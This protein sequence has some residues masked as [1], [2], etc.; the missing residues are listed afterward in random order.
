MAVYLMNVR[1]IR[2]GKKHSNIMLYKVKN[3]IYVL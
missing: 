3:I 2:I 1:Y